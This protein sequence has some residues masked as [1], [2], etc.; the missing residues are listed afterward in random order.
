MRKVSDKTCRENQNT[1]FGFSNFFLPEN[2]AV[3]EITWRNIVEPKRSQMTVWLM[4]IACWLTEAT[5]TQSEYVVHIFLPLQ[6]WLHESV[7]VLRYTYVACL[8]CFQ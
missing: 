4:R 1:H 3:Y 5:D 7:S 2:S 6:K 8:V